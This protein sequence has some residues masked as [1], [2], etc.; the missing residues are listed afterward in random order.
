MGF[1]YLSE[2]HV[3]ICSGIPLLKQWVEQGHVP[4]EKLSLLCMSVW[5]LAQREG[6]QVAEV[7]SVTGCIQYALVWQRV[8][9]VCQKVLFTQHLAIAV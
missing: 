4:Q 5:G 1:I 3:P 7:P 2:K 6:Y 8:G 9:F